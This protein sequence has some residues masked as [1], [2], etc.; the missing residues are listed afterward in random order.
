MACGLNVT[1]LWGREGGL[2]T[3]GVE[4]GSS[5]DVSVFEE[6]IGER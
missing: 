3:V 4:G 2:A 5:G 6:A 1:V